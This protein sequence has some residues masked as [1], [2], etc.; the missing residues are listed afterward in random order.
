MGPMDP[1]VIFALG[2][3][4]RNVNFETEKRKCVSWQA[5]Q[6]AKSIHVKL[7]LRIYMNVQP[8]VM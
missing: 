8:K 4:L 2:I 5:H 6:K 7:W 1:D 3:F